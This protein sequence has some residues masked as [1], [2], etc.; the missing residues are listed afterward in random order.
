M[1]DT[2]HELRCKLMCLTS[3]AETSARELLKLLVSESSIVVSKNIKDANQA[4]SVILTNTFRV[5]KVKNIQT[6]RYPSNQ[7]KIFISTAV[8]KIIQHSID[9]DCLDLSLIV[10]ILQ[11]VSKLRTC[12]VKYM[13]NTLCVKCNASG[14]V[15]CDKCILCKVCAKQSR[16]A[17]TSLE[18]RNNIRLL[19]EL[20]NKA[21]HITYEECVLIDQNMQSGIA[22]SWQSGLESYTEAIRAVICFLR[23]NG[24]YTS[25]EERKELFA[26]DIVLMENKE[27]YLKKFA[28]LVEILNIANKQFERQ[29]E[30]TLNCNTTKPEILEDIKDLNS[31]KSRILSANFILYVTEFL[32]K[33]LGI[34][35]VK[36][37]LD[38]QI[39]GLE[40]MSDSRNNN[41]DVSA[42]VNIDITS[43]ED[44]I[45]S[46]Y[47]TICSKESEELRINMA[48]MFEDIVSK[49]FMSP[50]KVICTGWLSR[51]IHIDFEMFSIEEKKKWSSKN[52]Q[53]VCDIAVNIVREQHPAF[54]QLIKNH[55]LENCNIAPSSPKCISCSNSV[56]IQLIIKI[57]DKSFC[58]AIENLLPELQA[59]L[60]G[61]TVE[62]II[63]RYKTTGKICD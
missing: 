56:K 58:D 7:N 22:T 4:L 33:Q 43:V 32:K 28:G 29:L 21:M 41:N 59:L 19:Q 13:V 60:C 20:R 31:Q 44:S 52:I 18:L 57:V 55:K 9:I 39:R 61:N 26:V 17:C 45:P 11:N 30:I 37:K 62:D 42:K 8:G 5:N 40:Y 49:L 50:I 2:I 38:V 3:T 1:G 25:T 35:S 63:E 12:K 46:Y 6:L 15:C 16:S 14:T 27:I 48:I 23:L 36:N 54:M 24:V 34:T 51:S 53:S 47:A 10:D